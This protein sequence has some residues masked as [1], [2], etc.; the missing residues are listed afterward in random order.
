MQMQAKHHNL[1]YNATMLSWLKRHSSARRIYL[2]AAATTPVRPEVV[3]AMAPYWSEQFGNPGA[4]Y[5]EG[6]E[7]SRTLSDARTRAARALSV[8]AEEITFTSGGTEAN[9]MAI[10]GTVKRRIKD[11]AAPASLHLISTVIEHSSILESLKELE[12]AGVAVTYLP[13]NGDGI[14]DLS[15]LKHALRPETVLIT[16]HLVNNEIGVIQPLRDIARAALEYYGKG[17]QPY[18]HTDACQAPLFLNVSP[19][20]LGVDMLTLDGQKMYGPK[21][22]GLLVHRRHVRLAPSIVG[23]G[24]ERGLRSGTEPLSLIMGGVVA[25]EYAIRERERTASRVRALRDRFLQEL[26]KRV[27]QVH[28]NGSL[29]E[30]SPNNINVS[31]PGI[32]TELLVLYLDKEG[33][34]VSTRSTC[35]RD[36]PASYTVAALEKGSAYAQS[37]L[38]ITL[39]TNTTWKELAYTLRTLTRLVQ[40]LDKK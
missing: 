39:Q 29:E 25:L 33:I 13:V 31:L 12:V 40:K 32:D 19:E 1:L 10:F 35:L 14:I 3:A 27:P 23:G 11:G 16:V 7:A 36:E 21:G 15:A 6:L 8:R 9:N 4:S 38:R 28:V 5:Q 2:D 24:Q 18:L 17:K 30:R 37:T 20:R 22:I 34:A 26:R